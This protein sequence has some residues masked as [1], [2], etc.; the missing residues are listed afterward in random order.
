MTSRSLVATSG[1]IIVVAAGLTGYA[2]LRRPAPSAPPALDA[3]ATAAATEVQVPPPAEIGAAVAQ[4]SDSP[5]PTPPAPAEGPRVDRAPQSPNTRPAPAPERPSAPVSE[6]A[7]A[8]P[9]AVQPPAL[10]PVQS[11]PQ[12]AAAP[13]AT[14]PPP[15]TTTAPLPAAESQR[16]DTPRLTELTIDT[17]SV[18]GIKLD[19]QVS[20][21]TSKVEDR[22]YA[23]VTRDVLVDGRT[24]IAAG[25]RLE[26]AVTL[27]EPGGKFK[28][29]SRIGIQFTQ[30][31]MAD[32]TRIPIQTEAVIRLGDSPGSEATAKVGASAVV[33]ALIGGV[34]GGKKGAAIGAGA[35]AAGGAAAVKAGGR[36]EAVIAADAPL[37]VRLT[38]PVKISV[39][40]G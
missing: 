28:G 26:G 6:P 7:A 38:A 5:R 31:V 22:V 24:A 18:I 30:L 35:G 19:S 9:V 33:G 27:V 34:V 17:D 1:A 8:P 23:R 13:A 15:D 2:V 12:V 16:I 32:K 14:A 21:E 20:S 25:A 39:E 10:P 36:N 4:P 11:T 29:R 40:R 37:T 3:P